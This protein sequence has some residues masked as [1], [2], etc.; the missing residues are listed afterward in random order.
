MC[1]PS[2]YVVCMHGR[3]LVTR[4]EPFIREQTCGTCGLIC[5]C[6][7]GWS[8]V[9][10]ASYFLNQVHFV[11]SATGA[12]LEPRY[13]HII[14]ADSPETIQQGLT[15]L[16]QYLPLHWRSTKCSLPYKRE[17]GNTERVRSEEVSEYLRKWMSAHTTNGMTRQL[18]DAYVQDF[19]C[20]DYDAPTACNELVSAQG[21]LRQLWQRDGLNN[22]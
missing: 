1:A 15:V 22:Q 13:D 7:R 18:C 3:C 17:L 10:S 5:Q 20:F 19:L 4:K 9:A 8:H 14:R 6:G 21:A 16:E 12:P 2:L 11:D